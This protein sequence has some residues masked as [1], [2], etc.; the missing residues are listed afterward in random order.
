L[1]NIKVKEITAINKQ[2]IVLALVAGLLIWNL[3]NTKGISTDIKQYKKQIELIETKVDSAKTIDKTITVKIDS[4]QQR[5][6]GISKEIHYI[7][8]NINIIKKQTDEK[9]NSTN[10]FSNAELEQFFSNRYNQSNN[11]N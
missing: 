8:K 4:V 3:I 1:I 10:K 9:V 11:S 7:D 6:F 2:N 5:V